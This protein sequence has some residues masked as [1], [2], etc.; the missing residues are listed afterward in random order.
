M[1]YPCSYMIYGDAFV[2]LP[3]AAREQVYARMWRVLSGQETSPR[4]TRLSR[5]DRE[6]IVEI[7]RET[8]KE[9]PAFFAAF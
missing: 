1:K 9:L 5:A 3:P 8:V 6:A 2:A 7:L 4:Y